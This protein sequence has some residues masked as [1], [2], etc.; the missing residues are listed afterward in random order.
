MDGS[1]ES[2]HY[3]FNRFMT[4]VVTAIVTVVV[5]LVVPILFQ[6]KCPSQCSSTKSGL[7]QTEN[8]LPQHLTHNWQDLRISEFPILPPAASGRLYATLGHKL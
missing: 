6:V 3:Y 2:I 4:L 7:T 5:T 8:L 1:L